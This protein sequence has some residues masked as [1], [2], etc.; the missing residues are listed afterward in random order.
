MG[1]WL[2]NLTQGAKE[3]SVLLCSIVS[4]IENWIVSHSIH[5]NLEYTLNEQTYKENA[6]L[7]HAAS[8]YS[9]QLWEVKGVSNHPNGKNYNSKSIWS[10]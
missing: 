5:G 10:I 9:S 8:P 7:L 2:R 3:T 1:M 4:G 6:V